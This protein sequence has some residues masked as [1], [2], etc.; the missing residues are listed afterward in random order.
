MRRS[1][2]V[3]RRLGAT[4]RPP[5]YGSDHDTLCVQF[6]T[7]CRDMSDAG[8]VSGGTLIVTIRRPRGFLVGVG[9]RPRLTCRRRKI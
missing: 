4:G 9:A 7:F 6:V 5:G 3:A 2:D 1:A 8:A